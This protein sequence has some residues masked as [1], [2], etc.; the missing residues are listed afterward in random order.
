MGKKKQNNQQ[1][2]RPANDVEY[3]RELA[4]SEDIEANARAAA[5]NRRAAER[6]NNK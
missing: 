3:S 5:A 6:K 2:N 1:T 4:D